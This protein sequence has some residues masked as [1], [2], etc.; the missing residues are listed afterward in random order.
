M[1][2][3]RRGSSSGSLPPPFVPRSSPGNL[4]YTQLDDETLL[5]HIVMY[6][7]ELQRRQSRKG[8]VPGRSNADH[9]ALPRAS[10]PGVLDVPTRRTANDDLNG[11]SPSAFDNSASLPKYVP[12]PARWRHPMAVG[13]PSAHDAI[14]NPSSAT[15]SA[16]S[17]SF[18]D[19]TR[20]TAL[21]RW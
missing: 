14:S 13:I 8:L 18:K 17:P 12:P 5:E 16:T 11:Y 3:M 4:P 20:P 19:R 15:S 10:P 2:N 9:S 1:S 7:A 6:Q 21:E